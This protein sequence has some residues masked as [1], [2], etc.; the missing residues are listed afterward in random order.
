VVIRLKYYLDQ[1]D[2]C[3]DDSKLSLSIMNRGLGGLFAPLD[4]DQVAP[5]GFLVIQ[6]FVVHLFGSGE[7]ALRLFALVAGVASFPLFLVLA[8]RC[9]PVSGQTLAMFFF[10]CATPVIHYAV[11]AKPYGSDVLFS[12]LILVVATYQGKRLGLWATVFATV[13]AVAVWI[14][15][16]AVLMLAGVGTCGF[17]WAL[18]EKDHRR[19]LALVGVG[20][21]WALSYLPCFL[22]QMRDSNGVNPEL[23]EYWEYRGFP[24]IT[25]GLRWV[26]WLAKQ[27][28]ALLQNP[29]GFDLSGVAALTCLFGVVWLFRRR[30]VLL[31][32]LLAPLPFLVLAALLRQYPVGERLSLFYC[33]VLYLLCAAGLVSLLEKTPPIPPLWTAIVIA[34]LVI[35]FVFGTRFFVAKS[36]QVSDP[37]M[38]NYEIRPTLEYLGK[39]Y[40]AGDIVYVACGSHTHYLYYR[41]RCGL[42]NAE[43][44]MGSWPTGVESRLRIFKEVT[45]LLGRR[46]VWLL[47]VGY[48][49][50]VER[51][52]YVAYFDF[53]GKRKETF[54]VSET[55]VYLYDLSAVPGEEDM[56]ARPAPNPEG[57]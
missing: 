52:S 46:R 1:P 23:L 54:E 22:L 43:I 32:Y 25:P 36:S 9:L 39:H 29:G 7:H 51:S 50:D 26:T 28:F 31:T 12:L 14:S 55:G 5:F 10:A 19:A 21:V 11:R 2:L 53:L 44:F 49:A 56:R 8:R 48:K 17:L 34:L 41:E 37:A 18:K 16:P 4:Y 57:T 30:R 42:T 20:A 13:G 24:P 6:W 45:K 47:V 15:H 27:P 35:P 3:G 40:E 38:M 33:P